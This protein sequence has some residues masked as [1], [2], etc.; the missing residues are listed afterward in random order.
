M[1][2]HKGLPIPASLLQY[3]ILVYSHHS[4]ARISEAFPE[5]EHKMKSFRI[6]Q[7][8]TSFFHESIQRLNVSMLPHERWEHQ[9]LIRC[10]C[11]SKSNLV[12]WGKNHIR[13]HTIILITCK[14]SELAKLLKKTKKMEATDTIFSRIIGGRKQPLQVVIYLHLGMYISLVV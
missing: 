11:V 5:I 8:L 6:I 14:E 7:I 12:L 1:S 13:T 10:V 9:T 4:T 3:K 2:I